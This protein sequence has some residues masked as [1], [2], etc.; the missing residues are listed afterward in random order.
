MLDERDILRPIQV[1]SVGGNESR[2]KDASTER[3]LRYASARRRCA[4]K[5]R[6][7]ES[8]RAGRAAS[9]LYN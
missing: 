6:P 7:N 3:Y 1:L 8:V 9:A 4:D 5:L 2:K